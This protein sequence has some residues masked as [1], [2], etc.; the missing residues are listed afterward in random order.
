MTRDAD[1]RTD[2]QTDSD[3]ARAGEPDRGADDEF[4][5]GPGLLAEDPPP[6]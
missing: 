5:E 6:N 2:R 3:G 4:V 1:A